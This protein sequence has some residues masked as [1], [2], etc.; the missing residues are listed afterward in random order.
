MTD[1]VLNF[2]DDMG[3][4]PIIIIFL[5]LM[6]LVVHLLLSSKKLVHT[7]SSDTIVLFYFES[8]AYYE[9]SK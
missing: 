3:D 6:E 2:I 9:Y 5:T 1:L 4:Y 7:R 8:E